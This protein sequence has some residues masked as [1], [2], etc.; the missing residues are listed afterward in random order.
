MHIN[1]SAY[2]KFANRLNR[3]GHSIPGALPGPGFAVY[4]VRISQVSFRVLPWQLTLR[5][6]N[7]AP[8]PLAVLG[9]RH[10]RPLPFSAFTVPDSCHSFTYMHT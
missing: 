1:H 7:A 10:S 2:N 9:L 4:T 5:V 8:G 6:L 3:Y